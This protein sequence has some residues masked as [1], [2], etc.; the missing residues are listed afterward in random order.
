MAGTLEASWFVVADLAAAPILLDTLIDIFVTE[1]ASPAI[2]AH[3][4]E[5]AHEVLADMST[6]LITRVWGALVRQVLNTFGEI[7]VFFFRPAIFSHALLISWIE[8][9]RLG[10]VLEHLSGLLFAAHLL[11]ALPFQVAL[12][13]L[14]EDL[15]GAA[16]PGPQKLRRLTR[17]QQHSVRRLGS[18]QEQQKR[19]AQGGGGPG[20]WRHGEAGA[21]EPSSRERAVRAPGRLKRGADAARHG[22]RSSWLS[23]GEGH[24]PAAAAP[25]PAGI[26]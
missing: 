4:E 12:L 15:V 25:H 19:S 24:I 3:A 26:T 1:P 21:G 18:Q 9:L 22:L 17:P 13:G 2:C 6:L 23:D 8:I 5:V 7:W 10:V 20:R 14:L 16:L 11:H